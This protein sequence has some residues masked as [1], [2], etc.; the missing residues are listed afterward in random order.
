MMQPLQQKT[1]NLSFKRRKNNAFIVLSER[2]IWHI[3]QPMWCSPGSVLWFSRC[4]SVIYCV[5][6]SSSCCLSDQVADV[7]QV[8]P[9][10]LNRSS[11][12][13]N[14]SATFPLLFSYLFATYLL[15]FVAY[16]LLLFCYFSGDGVSLWRVYFV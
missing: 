9:L 3:W 16:F 6:E 10:S 1:R 5:S 4:F 14:L 8:S 2:E 7:E 12:P 11:G 15:F 13:E